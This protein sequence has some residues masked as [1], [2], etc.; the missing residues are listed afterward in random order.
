[1][2]SASDCSEKTTENV[3]STIRNGSSKTSA[4]YMQPAASIT[5]TGRMAAGTPTDSFA[6]PT[7]ACLLF[8]STTTA[9]FSGATVSSVDVDGNVES[10]EMPLGNLSN[11]RLINCC[12][13]PDTGKL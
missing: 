6:L 12:F 5:N 1:M 8:F 13:V 2:P 10:G 11:N 7:S 4:P 9:V 3:S